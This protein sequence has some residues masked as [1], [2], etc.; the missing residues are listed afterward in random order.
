MTLPSAG[1]LLIQPRQS[2]SECIQCVAGVS[3][4][5]S[6]LQYSAVPR[7]HGLLHVD[8]MCARGMCARG[9]RQ[10]VGVLVCVH[11]LLF[12]ALLSVRG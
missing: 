2:F 6:S 10:H 11:M 4:C 8:S 1:R 9:M 12:V 5:V 3:G 7:V